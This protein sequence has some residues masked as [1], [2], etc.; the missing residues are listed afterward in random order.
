M[1]LSH[2]PASKGKSSKRGGVLV[3]LVLLAILLS[4]CFALPTPGSGDVD[5][6]A[7]N[8][9][10]AQN[11][12]L[13]GS[14]RASDLVKRVD[15]PQASGKDTAE[16]ILAGW[17]IHTAAM[18]MST[19]DINTLMCRLKDVEADPANLGWHRGSAVY[20]GQTRKKMNSAWTRTIQNDCDLTN[21]AQA[22]HNLR[23]ASPISTV[24]QS[25]GGPNIC[26]RWTQ[27]KEYVMS[28]GPVWLRP[29][30]SYIICLHIFLGHATQ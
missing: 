29:K 22:I 26:I 12:E 20:L 16:Y 18:F 9:S 27:D 1:I 8:T 5:V 25:H 24:M 23:P 6:S 4:G 17:S 15:G 13:S 30:V 21:V 7:L 19:P 14:S 10:L 2:R 3:L 11:R 28:Q